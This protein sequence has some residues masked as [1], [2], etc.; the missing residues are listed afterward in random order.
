MTLSEDVSGP[1]ALGKQAKESLSKTANWQF[2]APTTKDW[3]TTAK[4]WAM[5][6]VLAIVLF[7]KRM[8]SRVYT[9]AENPAR[10]PA[11]WLPAG[12]PR[13]HTYVSMPARG[14]P[15]GVLDTTRADMQHISR[16]PQHRTQVDAALAVYTEA[17]RGP[18]ACTPHT[19]ASMS[20]YC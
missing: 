9:H 15:L 3:G 2:V 14:P 18:A 20:V 11:A 1:A 13:M 6:L 4:G 12:H 19:A 7:S 10:N 16:A 5:A 17:P 8:E